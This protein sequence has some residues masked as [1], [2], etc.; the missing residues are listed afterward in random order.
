MFTLTCPEC[1]HKTRVRYAKLGAKAGCP[2]CDHKYR[3]TE[4]T[5]E[6]DPEK[7]TQSVSVKDASCEDTA[8]AQADSMIR[9]VNWK[10]TRMPKLKKA[11]RKEGQELPTKSV[12][13]TQLLDAL[14]P[15]DDK[16]VKATEQ[17]PPIAPR[18]RSWFRRV[19]NL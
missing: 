18:R 19:L 12:V 14:R 8:E 2:A 7:L 1:G 3:L 17:L 4:Q 11:H 6:K 9:P 5:M 16:P 13:D 15:E 10:P